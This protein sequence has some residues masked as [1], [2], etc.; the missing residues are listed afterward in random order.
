MASSTPLARPTNCL[1]TSRGECCHVCGIE[2]HRGAECHFTG[3]IQRMQPLCVERCRRVSLS[4]KR[5][6]LTCFPEKRDIMR[7]V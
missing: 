5:L 7:I 6:L 4:R 3:N 2:D 1:L